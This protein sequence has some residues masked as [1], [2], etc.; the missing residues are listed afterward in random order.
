[1]NPCRGHLFRT[2]KALTRLF[3]RGSLPGFRCRDIA[4]P[5]ITSGVFRRTRPGI[6]GVFA[7]LLFVFGNHLS[8]R[9]YLVA[10]AQIDQLHALRRPSGHP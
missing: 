5:S 1:M 10:V 3:D 4:L 2:D 7:V 8:H 6:L 9:R